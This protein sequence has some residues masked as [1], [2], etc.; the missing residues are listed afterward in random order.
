MRDDHAVLGVVEE[1]VDE[2]LLVDGRSGGRKAA[3][4]HGEEVHVEHGNLRPGAEGW[5]EAEFYRRAL[6]TGHTRT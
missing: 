5:L 3:E 6:E 4:A 1:V 2:M